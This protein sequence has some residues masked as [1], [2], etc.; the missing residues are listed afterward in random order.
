MQ[1][2]ERLQAELSL[3]HEQLAS[4]INADSTNKTDLA[5]TS[6]NSS[7]DLDKSIPYGNPANTSPNSPQ[8]QDKSVPYANVPYSNHVTNTSLNSSQDLER[9]SNHSDT[10]ETN[11]SEHTTTGDSN[12]RCL[13]LAASEAGCDE[14]AS[15]T[16]SAAAFTS[17]ATTP[18][19]QA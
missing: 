15:I 4:S 3:V 16:N 7:Q 8:V 2:T 11:I 18:D 12:G 5:N 1:E 14:D 6:S 10:T 17:I 19:D 9:S 13:L